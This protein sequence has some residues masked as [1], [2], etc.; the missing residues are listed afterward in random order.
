MSH[1]SWPVGGE[2]SASEMC[3]AQDEMLR[4]LRDRMEHLMHGAAARAAEADVVE[5]GSEL[6]QLRAELSK[7]RAK[8]ARKDA[9]VARLQSAQ[10]EAEVR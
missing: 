1:L 7:L 4:E 6:A 2:T 8:L 5:D 9:E 10:A 3:G